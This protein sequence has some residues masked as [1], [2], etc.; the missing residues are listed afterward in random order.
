MIFKQV[1]PVVSNDEYCGIVGDGF[2]HMVAGLREREYIRE[3]FGS[4]ISEAVV[5]EILE[6]PEGVKLGGELK[7]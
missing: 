7:K 3:T 6:S 5:T 1:S 2:N 4:Y